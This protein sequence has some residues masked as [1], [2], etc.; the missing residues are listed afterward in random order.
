MRAFI[1]V[2]LPPLQQP[3]SWM[4]RGGGVL[5]PPMGPCGR[6]AASTPARL[7]SRRA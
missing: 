5:Y 6:T 7:S 2:G 4:V 3:F 1:D